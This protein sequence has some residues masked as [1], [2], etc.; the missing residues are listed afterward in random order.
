[1]S[2]RTKKQFYHSG[3]DLQKRSDVTI[4]LRRPPTSKIK[5]W[6][7]SERVMLLAFINDV[8]I[9]FDAFEKELTD[10]AK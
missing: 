6:S 7:L 4:D 3:V 10:A 5:K 8:R 1:M 2:I 9:S